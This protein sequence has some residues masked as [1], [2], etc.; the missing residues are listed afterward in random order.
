MAP[1]R[2]GPMRA[3]GG[4]EA[5]ASLEALV[6]SPIE[7]GKRE[8]LPSPVAVYAHARHS[9]S[10]SLR[11]IVGLVWLAVVHA[12]IVFSIFECYRACVFASSRRGENNR[13]LARRGASP[14]SVCPSFSDE[15]NNGDGEAAAAAAQT[16]QAPPPAAAAASADNGDGVF[17]FSAFTAT[18]R[19]K[20]I[21]FDEGPT[22]RQLD[23][24]SLP[25]EFASHLT[26]TELADI[27]EAKDLLEA[28]LQ[29]K[30]ELAIKMRRNCILLE[31]LKRREQRPST[32]GPNLVYPTEQEDL[33]EELFRY[34]RRMAELRRLLKSFAA[35]AGQE[36]VFVLLMARKQEEGRELPYRCLQALGAAVLVNRGSTYSKNMLN[37]EQELLVDQE[38]MQ[39][40][41]LLQ[42]LA[43]VLNKFIESIED[44]ALEGGLLREA[45]RHLESGRKIVQEAALFADHFRGFGSRYKAHIKEI[46]KN[47][48][49]FKEQLEELKR[50][51]DRALMA[52][53]PLSAT[54]GRE[55]KKETSS[56]MPSAFR[57]FASRLMAFSPFLSFF[58]TP[59]SSSSSSP[60]SSSSSPS[61]SS[62]F[63]SPS[64]SSFP[65]S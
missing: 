22:R 13:L 51:V 25:E 3:E 53:P 20:G 46:G 47:S 7:E 48:A 41:L 44:D 6:T 16:S 2:S 50:R 52:P 42:Q 38:G 23:L 61:S 1:R 4:A 17:S 64:S 19:T 18:L 31:V 9:S 11:V 35:V 65:P 12:A 21:N 27:Q 59:S 14:F 54:E 33:E 26:P 55:E 62:S 24:L 43:T 28:T 29:E 63:S 40:A 36:R 5:Q 58:S 32:E 45:E 37:R 8:K 30:Q 57:T 56:S 15:L 60:S 39:T 10:S 34:R 49:A